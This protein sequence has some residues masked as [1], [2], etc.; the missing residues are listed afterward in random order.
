MN[1]INGMVLKLKFKIII[2]ELPET[3]TVM[4]TGA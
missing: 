2:E 3:S 1:N 4:I